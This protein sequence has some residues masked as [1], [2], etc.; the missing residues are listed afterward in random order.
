MAKAKETS[1]SENVVKMGGNIQGLHEKIAAY[2]DREKKRAE[3]RAQL[4]AEAKSDREELEALGIRKKALAAAWSYFNATPEQREGFDNS[5][6]LAREGMGLPV[7][8][9]Q[10]ELDVNAKKEA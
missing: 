10:L 9:A 7:K 5:Y 3:V 4:N 2:R 1:G 6:I 8:G